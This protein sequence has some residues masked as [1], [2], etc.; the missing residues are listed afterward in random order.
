SSWSASRSRWRPAAP[1]APGPT[2]AP[3]ST[4][5]PARPPLPPP[6]GR[7]AGSPSGPCPARTTLETPVAVASARIGP[8]IVGIRRV[9]ASVCPALTSASHHARPVGVGDV[10]VGGVEDLEQRVGP[11]AGGGAHLGGG[12]GH[13][14][15]PGEQGAGAVGAA[16]LVDHLKARPQEG[17]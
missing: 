2:P 17:R 3:A 8:T 10:G 13:G 11:V 14:L 12:D 1:S 15:Q 16:G 9:T 6:A 4:P 7:R 5:E